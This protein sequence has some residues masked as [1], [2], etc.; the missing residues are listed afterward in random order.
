MSVKKI[1]VKPGQ[2]WQDWDHRIRNQKP[3]LFRV[4]KVDE[5]HAHVIGLD[6]KRPRTILLNRFVPNATGY[7]FF[8]EMKKCK[9][10][11]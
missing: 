9:A 10:S 5:R 11:G 8:C 1:R 4:V 6:G 7:R 3:R 2:I